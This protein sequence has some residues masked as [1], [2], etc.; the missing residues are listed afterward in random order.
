MGLHQRAEGVVPTQHA[1]G[2]ELGQHAT[3]SIP[4]KGSPLVGICIC[5]FGC[6]VS[7]L[8]L[9]LQRLAGRMDKQKHIRG[10]S[11]V[12]TK[13]S[14]LADYVS[15]RFV[16]IVGLVLCVLTG[17]IDVVS[18]QF[19]PQSL[20]APFSSASLAFNM[21]LAPVMHGEELTRHDA[22]S[23]CLII[24]GLV[25]T[26]V[27][28]QGITTRSY[29]P[30]ELYRLGLQPLFLL[31][32]LVLLSL[33]VGLFLHIYLYERGSIP[34][35]QVGTSLSYPIAAGLL[36]GTSV[37]VVKCQGEL[38]RSIGLMSP[39]P[40]TFTLF[41]LVVAGSQLLVNNRGLAQH[42]TLIVVPIFCST[43]ILSNASF[44]AI[45]FQDFVFFTAY[46]CY[47]YLAGLSICISGV[48]MLL[49]RTET[50]PGDVLSDA[51]E[52]KIV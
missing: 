27:A 48:L 40:L 42:S 52:P 19:A 22:T 43:F 26:I 32:I 8:G 20:L 44:G 29:S 37:L 30:D 2:V 23:T 49:W 12:L 28:G 25:L 34:K 18:Y 39:L 7:A 50:S 13:T 21:L 46:Q 31:A 36:G 9:N 1:V 15:A 14:V 38:V 3:N 33:L 35:S 17:V 5:L 4:H 47:I 41:T 51:E 11:R 24:T 10:K 16:N 45:F 6:V